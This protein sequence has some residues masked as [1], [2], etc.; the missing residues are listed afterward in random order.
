[1]SVTQTPSP[2]L[3]FSLLLHSHRHLLRAVAQSGELP[4]GSCA[5]AGLCGVPVMW[6]VISSEVL[7]KHEGPAGI[8]R[9]LHVKVRVLGG[10][11]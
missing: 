7:H 1:M 3:F 4:M 8:Y 5:C 2:R 11:W 10:F 6:G 9:E